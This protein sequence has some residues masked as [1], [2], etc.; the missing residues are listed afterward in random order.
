MVKW[1]SSSRKILVRNMV[2]IEEALIKILMRKFGQQIYK[3]S[4]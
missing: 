3:K 1:V 4:V 2:S